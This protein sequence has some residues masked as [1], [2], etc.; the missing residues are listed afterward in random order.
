MSKPH[1]ARVTKTS[2]LEKGVTYLIN[3]F[4]WKRTPL[5]KQWFRVESDI[6]RDGFLGLPFVRGTCVVVFPKWMRQPTR[7]D[8]HAI[9][10]LEDVGVYEEG[11][12]S[13]SWLQSYTLDTDRDMW[14]ERKG[15]K[16]IEEV[17]ERKPKKII[18][19][20]A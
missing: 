14:L 9:L 12:S 1:S 5:L 2:Q 10:F 20:G 15:N 7:V 19:V 16:L 18:L 17:M 4:G 11:Y 8:H 3:G 13:I 6:L